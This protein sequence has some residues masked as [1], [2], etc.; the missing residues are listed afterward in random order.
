MLACHFFF[1]S[2]QPEIH[3]QDLNGLQPNFQPVLCIIR[4]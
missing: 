4:L 3:V 2:T 1:N